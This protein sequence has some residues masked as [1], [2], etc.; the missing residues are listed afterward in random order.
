M[1]GGSSYHPIYLLR[2]E[3]IMH[4]L[5]IDLE[6][7]SS[8]DISKSGVYR[9]AEDK[10]FEILLF[11]YSIDFNKTKV[12]D[13]KSGEKIPEE[14]IEAIK[15][16]DVLKWAHNASFE[17]VCLSRYLRLSTQTYLDPSSWRCSMVYASLLGL[18]KALKDIGVVLELDKQ[19]LD[20]GKDLIRYFSLPCKATK[21]NK[22][23]T[24]NL[25]IHDISKWTLF[26]EYNKRDVDSE[27]EIIKRLSAIK[28]PD[29][30][31]R[32]YSESERINDRGVLIDKYLVSNAIDIAAKAN[33]NLLNSLQ[34]LTNLSNPNSVTQLKKWLIEQGLE[35]EDLGKKNVEGLIKS[36]T[37]HLISSALA[38]R[39]QTSKSSIKKYEAMEKCKLS[40]QRIRGMFQF[41]G[42]SR[43]GRFAS[44]FVQLQNLR[45]NHLSDLDGARELVKNGDIEALNILYDDIPDVL[46][47]LIRTAFI[48]KKN[49]KFIV[50]DFSA[51]EA[52][53]LAWYAGET[54]VLDA[55]KNGEDI[56]CATATKMYGIPVVKHG[57]NG[58]LRQKG[59]QANLACGYGGSIGALKAM[60]ALDAGL[61][62]EELQELVDS[63]RR[64]NPHIVKF[65]WD[66]DKAIRTVIKEHREVSLY[67][68]SI[69]FDKGVLFIKLPS[70]RA[71]AY[72][73]PRISDINGDITYEGIGNTK[74]WERIDSYGPKFVEN[75]VQATARDILCNSIHNLKAYDIVMHIH[76][77]VVI[78]AS[79]DTKLE[80]VTSLM[81]KS[82]SWASDLLL[83]A[84]G[85]ECN[86]YQKD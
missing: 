72:I 62:E 33:E 53:V 1:V 13:L 3:F 27:V 68:L 23:R 84:D 60:G 42:A 76:D 17:R 26:K 5:I 47:Q 57:I 37:N 9:Y 49:H 85:Y 78:E 4:N 82:P 41:Y 11:G 66:I 21:S 75:I 12:I 30:I 25:P 50:A 2:G 46:S 69:Y 10:E 58:D 86:F 77:E 80:E 70:G 19:K 56:Y 63:W 35:V 55:F 16:D 51:I 79:L 38:L 54:W 18:P 83:R 65:W 73:R 61:K 31:W 22:M 24:R 71:L 6:T 29:F 32:E 81:S 40:D 48:P 67:R 8:T 74:K 59:K 20:E 44:K 64:A 28:V 45:Q 36:T 14:V 15:S 39:L 43:T 34:N 7:Y 52:R